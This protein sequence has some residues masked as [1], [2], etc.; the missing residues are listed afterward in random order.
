MIS[1]LIGKKLGM[2]QIFDKEGNIVPVTVLEVGPCTVVALKENPLKIALGFETTKESFLRKPQQIFFKKLSVNPLR[3]IREFRSSD[4]KDYK[5]GQEIKA[6]LFKAGDFV[7]VTGT[8][9]GKG[10]QGGMK[11]HHWRGGPAAHGSMHHRR[12]GSI[13]ASTYPSRVFKGH[14][15]PGHMGAET[16]T[17]QSLRVM[18]VDL[19][20]N[21]I[22][23]KGAVPGN[24]KNYMLINRSRKRA[25]RAL[26]EVKVVVEKKVNPMKQS[27]AKAGGKS[28]K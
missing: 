24:K 23:V 1:G 28:G 19:D 21:T 20:S 3:V 25:F 12:V 13:G 9:I 6:D 15:M 22:L 7:D 16:V 26:D 11:R 18:Q 5:L 10:F 27:K 8:S 2:T 14:R 4:N 17:V